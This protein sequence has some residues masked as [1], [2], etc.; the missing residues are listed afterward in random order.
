MEKENLIT[1]DEYF[2]KVKEMKQKT[3]DEALD[4]FFDNSLMLLEKYKKLGQIQMMKKLMFVIDC[5]PKER[6]LV[7]KGID[8]FIYKDDI[9]DFI[10]SVESKVVKI[11]EL[12]N[13]PREIPDELIPVIEDTKEIFDEFFVLFT[14]YTGKVERK[15][16][17]ERRSKDPILF[18]AFM[19]NSLLNDRFYYIGDW[20]DEYCDLTLE[21]LLEKQGNDIAH[22]I[23][24]PTNKEELIE[25]CKRLLESKTKDGWAVRENISYVE[26]ISAVSKTI[27]LPTKKPGFF[28][29]IKNYMSGDK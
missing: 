19:K 8:V 1:P 16:Q 25:E 10:N 9:E 22:S 26:P 28:K 21:K 3:S 15:V 14:D 24:T 2:N 29:R 6:E 18:G 7:K 27:N 20:E 5:I 12:K 23:G 13:Y 4:R 11:I 17:A